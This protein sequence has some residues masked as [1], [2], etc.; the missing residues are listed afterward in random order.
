MIT[1]FYWMSSLLYGLALTGVLIHD[2]IIRKN[3]D[4]GEAAFR[5]LIFTVILF[6]LQDTFWG[7]CGSGI[8]ANDSLFWL[9]STIFHSSTVL[10]T[11]VWLEYIMT[12]LGDKV[13]HSNV[14]MLLG[15]LVVCLQA[16]LLIKN[17]YTPT[18]F[19]IENG[20]YYTDFLRPLAFAD[21]YVVFFVMFVISLLVALKETGEVR[22]RYFAIVAFAGFPVILGAF[23]LKYPDDPYYSIGYAFSCFIIH[24]FIIATD[25]EKMLIWQRDFEKREGERRVEEERTYAITD[26]LTGLLNRRAYEEDFRALTQAAL[27]DDLIYIAA[28][29][30]GLKN[31]NDEKGHVAGDEL[32][33]GAASCLKMIF[34]KYGKVYRTG[35]DEF[36]AIIRADKVLVSK[37]KSDMDSVISSWQGKLVKS[38]FISF[39]MAQV[40]EEPELSL[41]KIAKIADKRMYQNKNAFYIAKGVDRRQQRMAYK[42]LCSS[43]TKILKINL[44]ED[45]SFIIYADEKELNEN[46]G[47]SSSIITWLRNFGLTGNVHTDDIKSY[48][49]NTNGEHLKK[50]FSDGM[51]SKTIHY[52]RL[53]KGGFRQVKMEII[54]A[55]NY[56][57]ENQSLYLFVKDIE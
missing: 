2:L 50:Y 34:A 36:V 43:Y 22:K 40:A 19:H 23:Q 44:T 53:T 30:N 8:I 41:A 7:L 52:R 5:K 28:D 38:L 21:Q 20:V 25:R 45:N 6:C 57:N 4:Q 27:P 11:Y 17:A 54:T 24:M 14:Y 16:C 39:G 35:G 47:Y 13:A 51:K 26:Q 46:M 31:I 55:E 10:T 32:I 1:N 48:L 29:V 3:P 18:V 33:I 49:E 15:K 12:F 42:T 9:A 56:T 37:I